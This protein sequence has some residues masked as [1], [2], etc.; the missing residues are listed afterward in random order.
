MQKAPGVI[1]LAVG[2][3]LLYWG[4]HISQSVG[5]QFNNAFT[6]SPGDKPM[7]LYIVGAILVAVGIGQLVWKRK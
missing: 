7:W 4:Y 5:S 3:V 2:A 6:G 1:C